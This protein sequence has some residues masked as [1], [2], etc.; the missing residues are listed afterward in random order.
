MHLLL[1][2]LRD[3]CAENPSLDH[4]RVRERACI[5]LNCAA[6]WA[7]AAGPDGRCTGCVDVML[8]GG[9]FADT[10]L[11][12]TTQPTPI[13]FEGTS[14]TLILSRRPLERPSHRVVPSTWIRKDMLHAMIRD[15]R[16]N[17][18]IDV[19]C[20]YSP[21][22]FDFPG[23]H[24]S[25]GVDENRTLGLSDQEKWI[26][27]QRLFVRQLGLFTGPGRNVVLGSLGVGPEYPGVSGAHPSVFEE[28]TKHF[29]ILA[30]PSYEPACSVCPENPLVPDSEPPI[31]IDHAFGARLSPV[32]MTLTATESYIGVAGLAHDVPLSPHYAV[33]VEFSARP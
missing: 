24:G 31:W 19:Y 28:L 16:S 33:E 12:C 22:V 15:A 17:I 13:A 30:P 32:A 2:C 3:R 18:P 21:P 6:A 23:Y 11:F 27:E 10:R 1:D 9:P 5:S 25:Y 14:G 7:A 4:S 20:A 29:A 8:R 26:N